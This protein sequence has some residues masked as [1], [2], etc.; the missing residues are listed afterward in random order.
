MWLLLLPVQK[1]TAKRHASS[2]Q[3]RE[4]GRAKETQKLGQQ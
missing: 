2:T 4:C 1:Q 3:F